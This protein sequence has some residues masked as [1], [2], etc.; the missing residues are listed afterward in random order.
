MS[1]VDISHSRDPTSGTRAARGSGAGPGGP[2]RLRVGS[3][4]SRRPDAGPWPPAGRAGRRRP[5]T[6]GRR[7]V[8]RRV[9]PARAV[10]GSTIRVCD[11]PGCAA[12]AW[13]PAPAAALRRRSSPAK[14]TWASL[15]VGVGAGGRPGGRAEPGPDPA[16]TGNQRAEVHHPRRARDQRRPESCGE[17]P[18]AEVVHGDGQVETL[19]AARVA[20]R[21]SCRRC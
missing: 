16:P 11:Q 3:G 6:A 5:V 15:G 10:A 21:R 13:T 2:A 17:G 7:S 9:H 1:S 14:T 18:G 19:R 12:T 20:A 8:P 4:R